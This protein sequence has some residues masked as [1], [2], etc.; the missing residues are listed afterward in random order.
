MTTPAN[1][2]NADGRFE[3]KFVAPPS[4]KDW[5]IGQLKTHPAHF[6]RAYPQ[7]LVNNVY[8][9]TEN[10]VSY[11][12][13]LSGISRRV[14]VR[15]RWYGAHDT[16]DKGV[17]EVKVRRNQAGWKLQYPVAGQH[18]VHGQQWRG[19]ITSLKSAL[20]GD[21]AIWL[22][23]Y[24]RAVLINRYRR[25]YFISTDGAFRVTVDDAVRTYNQ[26]LSNSIDL[27]RPAERMPS[28][29]I[30]EVKF[31][32][33]QQKRASEILDALALRRSRHSKYMT[34]AEACF[35]F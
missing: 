23:Q 2:Q 24:S 13:N 35:S 19:L 21:G 18:L 7:R 9:D 5:V 27:K 25:Q 12:D 32:Q 29:V 31:G 34:G 4:S 16:P 1:L 22:D 3:L 6:R 30:V 33:G 20:P 10:L 28:G 11:D 8:F 17:L 15:Y 26:W 14:K